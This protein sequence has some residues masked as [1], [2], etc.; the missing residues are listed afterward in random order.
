MTEKNSSEMA[1]QLSQN[2]QFTSP[3]LRTAHA[4]TIESVVKAGLCLPTLSQLNLVHSQTEG[5]D[6]F[7]QDDESCKLEQLAKKCFCFAQ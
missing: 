1:E 3:V 2:D 5:T 7:L 6:L 4:K